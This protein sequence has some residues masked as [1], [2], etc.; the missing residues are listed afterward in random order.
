MLQPLFG[1]EVIGRK[2]LSKKKK[3]KQDP[4]CV[5]ISEKWQKTNKERKGERSKPLMRFLRTHSKLQGGGGGT[6]RGGGAAT[7][8]GKAAERG[9][10]GGV[11]GLEDCSAPY[12]YIW[13]VLVGEGSRK[14]PAPPLEAIV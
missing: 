11:G 8:E 9:A 2:M 14:E 1:E 12:M 13:L 10:E 7:E 6:G 5:V 4:P 3:S